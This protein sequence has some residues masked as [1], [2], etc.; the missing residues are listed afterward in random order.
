L[1]GTATSVTRTSRCCTTSPAP[2]CS[3]SGARPATAGRSGS[4]GTAP[5]RRA[6]TCGCSTSRSPGRAARWSPG[7]YRRRPRPPP[8]CTGC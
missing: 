1:H 7:G 8:R 2:G 4:R 6:R 5:R 3:T